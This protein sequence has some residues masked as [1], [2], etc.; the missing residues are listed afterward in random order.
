MTNTVLTQETK[1][2][3]EHPEAPKPHRP[4]WLSTLQFTGTLLLGVCVLESYFNFA[5]VGNE[6]FLQNGITG[7]T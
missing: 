5:G 2:L 1:P 7:L 3:Q 6:E 4:W